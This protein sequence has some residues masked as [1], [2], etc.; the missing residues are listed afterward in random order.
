[1]PVT[2]EQPVWL[3]TALLAVPMCWLGWRWLRAM[4]PL[5]RA[6]ALVLR[7]ALIGLIA[8]MLAGASALRSTDRVAVV[9]VIDASESVRTFAARFGDLPKDAQGREQAWDAAVKTW[10]EKARASRGTDDLVGAVMFDGESIALAAPMT[11]EF[12]VRFDQ[13]GAQGTDIASALR[14]ARAL[15][16][17]GANRRLVLISD[18]NQTT[19]DALAAAAE[20]AGD[21]VPVDVV[22]LRYAVKNEVI[23]ESV[24]AP[25]QAAA[26]STVRVRVVL[27]STDSASGKLELLYEGNP[28]DINE[29]EAGTGRRVTLAPGRN[30]EMIDVPLP[31]ATVHRFEPVFVPDDAAVDQLLTNNRAEAFTVTPGK[32]RVLIVDGVSQAQPGGAGLTLFNTLKAGE[33]DTRAVRPDEMPRDLLTLN[34]YDLIVLQNVPADAMDRST[35]AALAEYVNTLGGGLIMV[36]GPDSFGAGAWKGTP[37]EPILPVN[38]DLPE[39]VM[40]I[41]AAVALVID[42]SGSMARG[43]AGSARSKQQIANEGA[44]LAVLALDK[45]DV[46]TV[47]AFNS[48]PELVIAPGRNK[49]PRKNA[50]LVRAIGSNGGTNIGGALIVAGQQ[51]DTVRNA[52]VRHI[53]LLT[54]GRDDGGRGLPSLA[55]DIK[56]RGITI[57]TIGV[58]DDVDVAVLSAVAKAGGGKFYNV[59]DPSVLPRVFVKEVRVVR[60]PLIRETP[61]VPLIAAGASLAE[62]LG[63]LPALEGLVLTQARPSAKATTAMTTPEGEPVLAWWP[64]GRGRVA[65]FT[66]DAHPAWAARWVNWPG[67]ST[68]WTRLVRSTSRPASESN[69]ELTVQVTG[70]TLRVRLDAADKDGAPLDMLSVPG[71][72]YTPRGDSV[73]VRLTQTGP[74]SYE[75]SLPA[76]ETGNYIVALSPSSAARQMTPVIGG[77]SVASGPETRRLRSNTGLLERIAGVTGGRVLELSGAAEADLFN[78]DTLTPT[79]ASLPLWR[80][81]LVW[82]IIVLVLDI[83][84]R[85]LAWDRLL[86]REWRLAMQEQTQKR[87]SAR[88]EQAAAT[89][90]S[91]RRA[92]DKEESPGGGAVAAPRGPVGAS[93]PMARVTPSLSQDEAERLRA[94]RLEAEREH[95]RG[96]LRAQMLKAR[97]AGGEGAG[98]ANTAA[99]RADAEV[100]SESTNELL[101]AKRRVREKYDDKA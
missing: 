43:M 44:A 42:N 61:F 30:V 99:P 55:A 54:D 19:G 83:G 98:G 82:T 73:Q 78:R 57:S 69:S 36:G 26:G 58:G 67:Y 65:A 96:Q 39:Q 37:I 87:V 3:W 12:D 95:R 5:R 7:A 88:A 48:E 16:P 21:K 94:E 34:A 52:G 79:I 8:C 70:D 6:S 68:F 51:L 66:S 4:S 32:G 49:D 80:T 29:G 17:A 77:A 27:E 11:G 93:R 24:D 1:M 64:A 100:S 20:L 89:L 76:R 23:V 2:F 72:V 90:R 45:A 91:L 25:P 75:A 38:L 14:F 53:I 47:V 18:G 59:T 81:L 41:P 86:N 74:G 15:F 22:P 92:A 10:L 60:K 40:A 62:G 50:D 35:Q 84:T 46:L 97:S 85:R 63:P 28:L 9:A 33:I 13:T 31:D 56:A 101:K 71:T